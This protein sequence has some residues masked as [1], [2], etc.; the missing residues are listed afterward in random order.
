MDGAEATKTVSES[1]VVLAQHMGVSDSNLAG[2]VHGG[3]IMK[4][5]DTA[6]GLA[7]TKF[8][9]R[10]VVTAAIDELSFLEPV[11]LGDLVTVTASVNGVGN[12]SMEVGVKVETENVLT[13]E[14]R[15]TATAYLLYVA[16]DA[17]TRQP[18]GVPRLVAENAEERRRM[19]QAKARRKARVSRREATL[20][21]RAAADQA[22]SE[23][24]QAAEARKQARLAAKEVADAQAA[25]R[26]R[27]RTRAAEEKPAPPAEPEAAPDELTRWRARSSEP[28]LVGAGDQP[29]SAGGDLT[30]WRRRSP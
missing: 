29:E 4:L 11:N 24:K 3:T 26:A 1:R 14:R 9:G 13:G 20:A 7:A 17:E 25:A 2:A 23:R 18:V 21:A 27:S 6:G 16:L 10:P 15:H 28:V 5:V 8:S 30:R 22:A 19:R 12:T